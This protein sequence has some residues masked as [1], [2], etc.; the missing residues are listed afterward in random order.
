MLAAF[1]AWLKCGRD[2][3][4]VGAILSIALYIFATLGL[5]RLKLFH[6]TDARR[7]G[8]DRTKSERIVLCF[9]RLV[10]ANIDGCQC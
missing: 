10:V 7:I 3:V 1:L 6:K 9:M 5:Y 8:T 4:P 2:V